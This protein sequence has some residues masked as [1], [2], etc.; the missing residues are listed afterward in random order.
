MLPLPLPLVAVLLLAPARVCGAS[1]VG[2]SEWFVSGS[3]GDD[4]W[5]G[6]LPEPNAAK[7]DGPVKTI[8]RAAQ[9]LRDR[10]Q[11]AVPATVTVAAGVYEQN[12]TIV[13]GQRDGGDSESSRVTWR[14]TSA[15]AT[16]LSFG[17]A[18][19][20]VGATAWKSVGGGRW[21][22]TLPAAMAT[23]SSPRQLWRVN[24]TQTVQRM[25]RGR[26]PNSGTNFI[27]PLGGVHGQSFNFKKGDLDPAQNMTG[28]EVVVYASWCT[29]R[30]H[31]AA[32]NETTA[33]LTDAGLADMWP[34]S[35]NRYYLENSRSF[36]DSPGE[37]H[38]SDSD[39]GRGGQLLTLFPPVGMAHP[40]DGEWVL[41]AGDDLK[42]GLQ[43]KDDGSV[44][45]MRLLAAKLVG[46]AAPIVLP[47]TYMNLAAPRWN[48]S[49][50]LVSPAVGH[51]GEILTR[52]PVPS[53]HVRRHF[54]SLI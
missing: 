35:G 18:R 25:T 34:N 52:G 45:P 48:L 31:I 19:I 1:P 22:Y 24:A 17:S 39:S 9:L 5:T 26:S 37:W 21:Q 47:A 54:Y 15:S 33:T 51:S 53:T 23:G 30:H 6:T 49:F 7:S 11:R 36:V 16:V 8:R 42:T 2:S 3:N 43:L 29:T 40:S 13:L 46:G 41:D 27:I 4:G 28:V 20:P 12:E 14:G 44:G 50:T 10:N 32:L 38:I